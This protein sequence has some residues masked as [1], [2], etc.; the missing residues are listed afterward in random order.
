MKILKLLHISSLFVYIKKH[1]HKDLHL[2]ELL[3]GSSI[4]FGFRIFAM[5]SSYFFFY[6][7]ARI[8]G[9]QGVGIFSTSWT[10]LMISSIFGK[11]GF[12]SSIV[13]FIAGSVS[14]NENDHITFIYRK[15]LFIVFLS[16][17]FVA[18]LLWIFAPHILQ[19]FFE[20]STNKYLI[21]IMGIA[22]VPF[23][24]M[25]FNAESLRA[26]K[27][28]TAFSIFQNGTIYFVSLLLLSLYLLFTKNVIIINITVL[29]AITILVIISFFLVKQYNVCSFQNIIN[30]KISNVNLST[31]EALNISLPMMLTNSLFFVMN[32]TDI[33][34]LG[35]FTNEA[36][37]GIYSTAVKIAALNTLA[38]VAVNSIA[39]PKFVELYNTSGLKKFRKFVWQTTMLNTSI[40]LP[41]FLLI[42][43]TPKFLL[44]IFGE[45]FISGDNALVILT[46]GQFFSAFA[47]PTIYILNM[48]GKENTVKNIFIV[49]TIVNIVL[50]YILIPIYGIEG[51][52]IATAFS[53]VF[54]NS[55]SVIYIYKFHGFV[56]F[57]IVPLI[58]RLKFRN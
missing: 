30:R 16:S 5:L 40:S 23:T 21:I 41:I 26:L 18:C 38:L 33:L 22:V 58:R 31:R 37:V 4:A 25:Q 56:T 11:L 53:M 39:S 57:P 7:I 10:I 6:I 44:T 48:T 32:W 2:D 34:M 52:A 13:R 17:C 12:D 14:R 1:L 55:L 8:F 9:A 49:G 28:I 27:K 50:N 29:T 42:V 15:C 3:K 47:G 54:W 36:A 43:I 46:F 19:I 35:A 24:I 20:H 51:A 45:E